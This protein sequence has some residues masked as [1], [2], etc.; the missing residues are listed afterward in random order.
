MVMQRWQFDWR[1]VHIERSTGWALALAVNAVLLLL[2]T[3]P[4]RGIAPPPAT[5][6]SPLPL[7]WIELAAAPP[8]P[9]APPPPQPPLR[10]RPVLSEVLA[11]PAPPI[12]LPR[13]EM[14]VPEAPAGETVERT[15]T[16]TE[17]GQPGPAA[18]TGEA[19]ARIDYDFAPLPPYPRAELIRGT[20]GS[21][22]LRVRVDAEGRVQQVDIERSSGSRALDR[23]AQQQV[24]RSWRFKPALRDGRPVAGWVRVPIE[25]SLQR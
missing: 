21:V 16:T 18:P 14:S 25:F 11:T 8:A 3:L 19:E 13:S 12:A 7:D 2:L 10:T 1:Q 15:A 6:A 5:P 17:T 4:L 20:E 23:A 24:A 9:P 22:L